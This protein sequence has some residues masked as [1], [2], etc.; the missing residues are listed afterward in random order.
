[1]DWK[2]QLQTVI[3]AGGREFLD[4]RFICMKHQD[5]KYAGKWFLKRLRVT[6]YRTDPSVPEYLSYPGYLF[7]REQMSA[8]DFLTFLDNL[9]VKSTFLAEELAQLSDEEKLK[10]VSVRGWDIWYEDVTLYYRDHVRSNAIW[11]LEEHL[12]PSWSF[13]GSIRPEIHE[14]QEALIASGAPHFPMPVN[15]QAWYLYRKPLPQNYSLPSIDISLDDDRA[16]FREIEINVKT[17]TLRCRCEGRLLSQATLHLYTDILQLE[18][19]QA[20]LEVPFSLQGEPKVFSLVLAIGEN[21]LDKREINLNY[22]HHGTQRG[23]TVIGME[24]QSGRE[25]LAVSSPVIEEI[26]QSDPSD[27]A[28][29]AGPHL[30]LLNGYYSNALRQSDKSF[31]WAIVGFIGVFIFIA[32]AILLLIFRW[33]GDNSNLAAIITA[34]GGIPSGILS[35]YWLNLHKNAS[36]QAT[37]YHA[38][39]DRI[40]R[41]FIG[42]SA[43]EQL[44]EA[45]KEG[46][47]QKLI[48]K[49]NDL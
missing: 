31:T 35:G 48:E 8:P 46:M 5:A 36:T 42:N 27:L 38:P 9:T 40:Q 22:F 45:N 24:A 43:C 14:G 6:L 34:L 33:T 29:I 23:V 30:R 18:K 26:V 4:V 3:G 20:E 25:I 41:F 13:E 7:V 11:G 37:T 16:F 39:L 2:E 28:T 21:W 1:M 49:L 32:L 12:L 10:K 17:S 15:G 44:Q 19:T 47:R